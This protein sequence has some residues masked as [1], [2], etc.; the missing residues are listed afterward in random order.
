MDIDYEYCYDTAG[1]RHG[2]CGQVTAAY[3][4]LNA[5]N[6][7]SKLTSSLRQKLDEASVETSKHYE[8]SHVPMDADLVPN[9]PYYQ[10]LKTQHWNLNF[11]A[12]QFYNSITRPASSDGFSGSGI[13]Q[14]SAASIYDN[15]ANDIFPEQPDKVVFGFCISDCGATGS[16]AS[17]SQ[18][19]EVMEEIKTY[20]NG[21]F[22][23][24]GGGKS[25]LSLFMIVMISTN[26]LTPS[27]FSTLSSIFLGH[28]TRR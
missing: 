22:A 18:A 15:I 11:V 5:Q 17:G 10:I 21:E 3:S 2:G 19:A 14:V 28:G 1:G 27:S 9:S 7:L 26:K 20:N 24:N 4:D 6:F 8:L 12:V 16:N 13:G 23:C 25:F